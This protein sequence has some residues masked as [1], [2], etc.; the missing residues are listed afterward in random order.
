MGDFMKLQLISTLLFISV[1]T[2]SNGRPYFSGFSKTD[3]YAVMASQ[4]IDSVN[5]ELKIV[6]ASSVVEKDAY[7]GTLMM[8]KAGLVKAISE[9][10]NLFRSGRQK[11]ENCIK[12]DNQNA[13]LRFLRLI[14]QEN[15]PRIV[16]YKG[17]LQ[18]DKTVIE[19]SFK[20]LPQDV[21]KCILTYSKKSTILNPK[22]F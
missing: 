9:K 13:E 8:T 11:L 19:N 5:N 4:N 17:D 2:T 22:D 16:N 20:T 12:L 10:I 14:I 7:E 3:Y 1:I 18:K 21:Q 6:Q 15:A